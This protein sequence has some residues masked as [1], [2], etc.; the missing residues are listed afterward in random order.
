MSVE[1]KTLPIVVRVPRSLGLSEAQVA[2]LEDK[3][4]DDLTAAVSES[5]AKIKVKWNIKI[6]IEIGNE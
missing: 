6:H 4:K 3:W 1:T 5:G 2:V